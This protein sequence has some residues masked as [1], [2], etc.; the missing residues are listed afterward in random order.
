MGW[1]N[2]SGKAGLGKKF[3][4]R[5]DFFKFSGTFEKLREIGGENCAGLVN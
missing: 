1:G 4:K 5:G 3:K 2:T